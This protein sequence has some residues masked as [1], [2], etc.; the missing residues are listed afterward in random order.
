MSTFSCP[1]ARCVFE[2]IVGSLAT[3]SYMTT[4]FE[5]MHDDLSKYN[6]E[7]QV[8][9]FSTDAVSPRGNGSLR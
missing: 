9:F 4:N 1:N 7:L 6:N 3:P 5:S 8:W 2:S